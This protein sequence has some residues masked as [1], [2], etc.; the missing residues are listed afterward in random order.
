MSVKLTLRKQLLNAFSTLKVV[1]SGQRFRPRVHMYLVL[2]NC[3]PIGQNDNTR[4][5]QSILV[6]SL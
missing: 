6:V 5:K 1:E 3:D 2:S 4:C